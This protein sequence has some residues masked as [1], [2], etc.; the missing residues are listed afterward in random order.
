ML[1]VAVVN[2]VRLQST[3]FACFLHLLKFL[4]VDGW[5]RGSLKAGKQCMLEFP[6]QQEKRAFVA[7]REARNQG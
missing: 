7:N 2:V 6:F 4:R 5:R 1:E 3:G